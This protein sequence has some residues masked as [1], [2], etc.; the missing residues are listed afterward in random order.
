LTPEPKRGWS[1]K[2]NLSTICEGNKESGLLIGI[3]HGL[4]MECF[5]LK[6]MLVA[7]SND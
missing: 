7:K 4:T 5:V 3:G 2:G 6:A 1:L